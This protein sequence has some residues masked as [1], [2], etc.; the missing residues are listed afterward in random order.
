[1]ATQFQ[2][3]CLEIPM[4]RGA[5]WVTVHWVANIWTW[6]SMHLCMYPLSPIHLCCPTNET[7]LTK[8]EK[9][10]VYGTCKWEENKNCLLSPNPCFFIPGPGER[11]ITGLVSFFFLHNGCSSQ[12]TA[13]PF[14]CPAPD[15]GGEP[16]KRDWAWKSHLKQTDVNSTLWSL[17]QPGLTLPTPRQLLPLEENLILARVLS[18]PGS[19]V[20][21]D[22]FPLWPPN[23]APLHS[24]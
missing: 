14:S 13:V 7:F 6:L 24:G 5:W 11:A 8:Q 16:E 20:R 9:K 12:G 19:Q 10:S 23:E 17:L 15:P 1:M 4:D 21:R 22:P 18:K 2:Y 3:S